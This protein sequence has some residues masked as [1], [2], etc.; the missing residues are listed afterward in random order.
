MIHFAFCP[1]NGARYHAAPPKEMLDNYRSC[2]SLAEVARIVRLGN[3]A[4]CILRDAEDA[5]KQTEAIQK[6]AGGT[7]AARRIEWAIN[8]A[9]RHGILK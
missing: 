7:D 9:V 5:Q 1:K 3:R 8:Y 6:K 2:E 4:R